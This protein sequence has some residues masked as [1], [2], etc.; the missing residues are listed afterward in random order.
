MSISRGVSVSRLFRFVLL[1]TFL[2]PALSLAQGGAVQPLIV[3]PLDLTKL[4]V[5]KGNTHPLAK[6]QYDQGAAPASLPMERMLLVLRRSSA[7]EA[8]LRKLLDDQQDKSSPNYHQ[9]LTPEQ[10]GKQ[11]GPADKDIQTITNWLQSYGFQI[12]QVS[13]GRTIIEFSGTAG[14][15]QAALHTSIHKYVMNG[16]THWANAS[17]PSIPAALTP[18]VV[19]VDSLNNFEKKAQNVYAGTYSK[20]TKR[21]TPANPNFT[22]CE[23]FQGCYGVGPY[24]FATI[25]DVLPLWNSGTNGTGQTIAIVGRTDINPQDAPDFW[26]LF[27]LDGVHAPQPTLQITY[28]GPNPGIN[29]D[30]PEADIDT[31]WSGAVAPGAIINFVTSATTLTTDGIDLSAIYIVDNNLAP[32]MSESYGECEL[33]LGTAGN[34]FYSLLWEQAAAQGI[35]AFVSSGDNGAASCDNPGGP[36]QYGLNVNGLGSTPF[37]A[38]VGGTDF[39]EFNQWSN[40]WNPTDDPITQESAKGYIP[41]TTWDNSCTNPL[42]AT[43]TGGSTHAEANCNNPNFAG[44]LDSTGGSGG[45]SNCVENSQELGSCTAGYAK[46]SWQ[47]GAGVPNDS[48]RDMPDVSMFASNGFVG[49]IYVICQS[50]AAPCSLSELQGYG[51]TSV[52]TPAFAG[53]MSLVNQKMGEPQGVPGFVLY[54]LAANKPLSF[55]DTPAGSTI[56]M[57]CLAGSQDC[58]VATTGHQY[59]VLSGYSTAAGYDLAT[60]LGSVDANNLVT[61]WDTVTFTATTTNLTLNSGTPVNI[62]HGQSVNVNIGVSP[63]AATGDAS[64]LVSTGSGTSTGQAID[65]YTLTTGAVSGTTNLLPGGTYN[66]VAHYAGNGTYGGSYSSPVSVTVAKE[67]STVYMPGVLLAGS[68]GTATTVTYGSQYW[69]RVD[70]QNSQA[71]FCNPLPFGEVACPSGTVTLTAD[72][73]PIGPGTYSLNSAGSLETVNVTE[74]ELTGGTH[75]LSAQYSGDNSYK[76]SSTSVVITVN[77]YTTSMAA[78]GVSGSFAGQP[79]TL[80][81]TVNDGNVV[82]YSAAPT[83]QVKFYSN[84]TLIPGTV[85][86]NTNSGFLNASLTATIANPGTY[87]I[88]SAYN[89]DVNYTAATSTA[90]S[91]I[92]TYPAPTMSLTPATQTVSAGSAAT[93]TA[94]V[95]TGNTATQATG[96]VSFISQLTGVAIPGTPTYT[97]ITDGSG[98]LEMKAVFSYT[99]TASDSVSASYSGDTNYPAATSGGV[100]VIVSG[101]DFT[102]SVSPSS[103]SVQPS[104]GGSLSVPVGFQ[105]TTAAVTFSAT[106]CAGLPAESTCSVSP[107]SITSAT[108]AVLSVTTTGPHQVGAN[109]FPG[110]KT[111]GIWATSFAMT[112]AGIFLIGGSKKRRHWVSLLSLVVFAFLLILPAC[113]G[114]S[115]GGGGGGGHTDPGTPAGTYTITVTAA[116]GSITHTA[117][118]SL[119]VQ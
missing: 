82:F 97:Q 80:T 40:Y 30:E 26:S 29:G 27:G 95:D 49:S 63:T 92:L 90:T 9:W 91:L 58:T 77:K 12:G 52:A 69:V 25:Y 107:I 19:G 51:G 70:M 83:G 88:T 106:P 65:G 47:S 3:Q 81:A 53:I 38:S 89:G 94:L 75:T 23:V 20:L 14:Q 1:S 41:E 34:Q 101:S 45:K 11:F 68:G 13:N 61:N 54:K 116:S 10:F 48:L 46:P 56:A 67:N 33:G 111:R 84:G 98:N 71:A 50:D 37:N 100:P 22:G 32:V 43:L 119:V 8:T 60:G 59:G 31:Q 2:I 64:L 117:T 15:V 93:L 39:N 109:R 78:P 85:V 4:T 104:Q 108:T 118:F 79:V 74:I 7:Q 113:G 62:T 73:V 57:P 42:L 28:N 21:L 44:F 16:E 105:S 103:L 112:F 5:L 24:D 114:G 76:A 96:T 86:Y 102:L 18:A 6:S 99:P 35:S 72:S 17:D 55:H 36:A 66:V 87:A 115:G 110:L